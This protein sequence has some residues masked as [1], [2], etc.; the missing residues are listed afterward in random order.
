M[1][2]DIEKEQA[3]LKE[4]QAI[5][6]RIMLKQGLPHIYSFKWYKWA[7]EFFETKN[8]IALLCAANQISKSST[9]MRT[10]I[11]W[12]TDKTKWP[13]L[14]NHE[15]NQ[16]WYLYPTQPQVNVEFETKWKQFLPKGVFKTDPIYGWKEEKKDGNIIAVH[17][18]SGVHLYFKTYSQ[19]VAALQSGTCDAIFCDEELPE[20]LFHELIFRISASDGYFRMVF[21]ATLG[22][23]FWR[24]AMEVDSLAED[25]VENLPD[26]FKL[27]VSLYACQQYED[28]TPS[29][30]T[31]AK[32]NQVQNRCGT[33][34]EILKRVLGRFVMDKGGL[35]YPTFDYTRHMKPHHI[36]PRN[37]LI[38]GGVDVGGGQ[39]PEEADEGGK[40]AKRDR[41][42]HPAAICFVATSPDYKTGRVFLGWRGDGIPTTAGDVAIKYK[43][44]KT[45]HKFTTTNQCYDFASADFFKIA[46]GLGEHFERANKSH[47]I[48]EDI[49]NV[50]F[51]NDMLFIYRTPELEKLAKELTT[52]RNKGTRPKNDFIDALRYT[53]ALI[54][55]DWSAISAE[56]KPDIKIEEKRNPNSIEQQIED[57]RKGF[58]NTEIGEEE[59]EQLFNE[60]NDAY[61]N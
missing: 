60:A 33:H 37:W 52:L 6:N 22:Q 53:C 18:N 46:L 49:L 34:N 21:T 48:G 8:K 28:G 10:C 45:A 30:W 23:D 11:D 57:R 55:W 36:V 39:R 25:E 43:S 31:E 51:K 15:P 50:L 40:V 41:H 44:L 16:F 3:L 58:D 5:E 20:H 47:D 54:P 19:N 7:R 17:F 4:I 38:F 61:G 2:N 35:K 26:A 13:S 59:L 29:P 1:S 27:C 32:I 12:A 9:Q 14:W 42:Q 56:L 24:R